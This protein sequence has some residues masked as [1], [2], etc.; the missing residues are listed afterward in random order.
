MENLLIYL[1]HLH[2]DASSFSYSISI[3]IHKSTIERKIDNRKKTIE[4][5][6]KYNPKKHFKNTGI[7]I[8]NIDEAD[9][10]YLFSKSILLF[11]DSVI[12]TNSK[13]FFFF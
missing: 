3:K 8:E 5:L 6:I 1:K 7:A 11:K 13:M 4:N 10:T 12:D 2:I 9:K